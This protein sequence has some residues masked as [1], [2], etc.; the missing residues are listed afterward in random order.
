[1]ADPLLF[2]PIVLRELEIRNR[3]WVAPMCQ[4]SARDGIVGDWHLQHLGGLA[5]GGAGLVIMEA[6][7]VVSEGR[8]S[9]RCPGIWD[10]AQLPGLERVVAAAHAH[11]ARIGIQLAHA[12]R[13]GSTHPSLPGFPDGSVPESEGGWTTVA[14][15][16]LAFP[17]LAEPR[18]LDAE[19]LPGLVRAFADGAARAVAA[20]FD[21]VEIHAAHGYLLHEFLSPLSNRRTDD[22]GGDLAGRA[23]LLREV[24]RA[25]RAEQPELPVIVRI[26]A[27]DWTEGGL[28]AE[29]STALAA[30]IAADGADLVDVSSGANVPARIPV[31]PSYQV[32][33]AQAVRRGPLPVGAVGLITSATQAEGILASGQAD[34]ILLGR[35]VLANPHLPI[36]WA[37]ELRAPGAADLV[38]PQYARARF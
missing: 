9:P 38:P 30:L 28:D 26:S 6:T 36:A 1:M 25:I 11:G 8:I 24:V 22:Y 3:L 19:E 2:Q 27:T 34:V 31:G 21:L 5:R 15:S 16:A 17:G 29:E 7:A 4:Y 10:D 20:G 33:L 32:P 13:K 18:A 14:P 37:H 35:P 23:R 12:G